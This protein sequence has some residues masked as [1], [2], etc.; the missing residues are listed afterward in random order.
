LIANVLPGACSASTASAGRLASHPDT[1][2]KMHELIPARGQNA[3][4]E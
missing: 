3:F 2:A 4:H 1:T